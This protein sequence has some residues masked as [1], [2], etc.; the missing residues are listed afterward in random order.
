M[1]KLKGYTISVHEKQIR[2]SDDC[3]KYF[4]NHGTP[5]LNCWDNGNKSVRFYGKTPDEVG[6][7]IIGDRGY[8]SATKF[9][10]WLSK[11]G[12]NLNGEVIQVEIKREHG[13]EPFIQ[14]DLDKLPKR[15]TTKPIHNLLDDI[16]NAEKL[17]LC[18]VSSP[19]KTEHIIKGVSSFRDAILSPEYIKVENDIID[20]EL[21][22]NGVK[23]IY[24]KLEPKEVRVK[25]SEI[26]SK[27]ESWIKD[28]V[29]WDILDIV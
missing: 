19:V 7:C 29:P 17:I 16:N 25:Q 9:I 4:K 1:R 28:E 15:V 10:K 11:R 20:I 8:V 12:Y 26:V 21:C 13:G 3:I 24:N 5:R 2:L 22:N 23:V 6:T 18:S 14:I 27:V